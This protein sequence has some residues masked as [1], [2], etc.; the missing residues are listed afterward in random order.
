MAL[1]NPFW[2]AATPWSDEVIKMPQRRQDVG[3]AGT[4]EA[5]PGLHNMDS[6]FIGMLVLNDSIALTRNE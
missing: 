3:S 1:G 4:M 6:A 2:P 5:S